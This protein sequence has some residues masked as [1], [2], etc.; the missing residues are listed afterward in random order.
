[1]TAS[2]GYARPELLAATEWLAQHLD[3]PN[4]RI[5]ERYHD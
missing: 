1:M 5:K 4:I 3:D 2:S